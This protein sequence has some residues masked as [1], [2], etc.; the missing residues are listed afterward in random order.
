MV[1]RGP[2]CGPPR[3]AVPG[4]APHLVDEAIVHQL[5]GQVLGTVGCSRGVRTGREAAAP[6]A[7]PAP[8]NPPP[9]HRPG[10]R[11]AAYLGAGRR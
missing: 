8:P 4:C 9:R 2:P 10:S 5:G 6:P 1:G 11:P 3:L 7:V